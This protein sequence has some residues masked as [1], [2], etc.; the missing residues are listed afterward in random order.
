MQHTKEFV[1]HTFLVT[2]QLSSHQQ[3]FGSLYTMSECQQLLSRARKGDPSPSLPPP[4]KQPP[5][6]AQNVN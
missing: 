1:W 5:E 4:P 6:E 3:Y 2:V